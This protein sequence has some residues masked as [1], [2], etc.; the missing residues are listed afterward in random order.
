MRPVAPE[1]GHS[2]DT[3]HPGEIAM[4]RQRLRGMLGT[5]IAI[6]VPWTALGLLTGVVFEFDLIPGVHF[7]LGRPIPG[8]FVALCTLAGALVGILNGIAFSGVV[9]ATERGKHVEEL[10]ASR[11]AMWGAV[12]TAAPLGLIFES[13]LAAG[14]GAAVGAAG[15]IA[16]LGLAHR[17]RASASSTPSPLA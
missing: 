13:P 12:A 10:R 4:I 8:G 2:I 11:F 5:T 3:T 6:C 1:L 7:G 16:V 9:L 15:G 14:I 17:T